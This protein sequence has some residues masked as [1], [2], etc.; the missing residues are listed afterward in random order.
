MHL[1]LLKCTYGLLGLCLAGFPLLNT[2][3]IGMVQICLPNFLRDSHI[4]L[5][6]IDVDKSIPIISHPKTVKLAELKSQQKS[7][8][9][10]Y[11]TKE[12]INKQLG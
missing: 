11:L 4:F 6:R 7:Q 3:L 8:A 1:L 2:V 5:T 12:D 10:I 9:F